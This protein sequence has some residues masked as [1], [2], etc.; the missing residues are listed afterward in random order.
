MNRFRSAPSILL[1]LFALAFLAPGLGAFG[2]L[3]ALTLT[4]RLRIEV[5]IGWENVG[6]SPRTYTNPATAP[7][8]IG[9]R[10]TVQAATD[11]AFANV[12]LEVP[13]SL[14]D[15]AFTTNVGGA[16]PTIV[17]PFD[18]TLNYGGTS[19]MFL[20]EPG[21]WATVRANYFAETSELH[22]R[23]IGEHYEDPQPGNP[24]NAFGPIPTG[25]AQFDVRKPR[26]DVSQVTV[27]GSPRG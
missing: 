19:G 26:V 27:S 25:A 7:R 18:G 12:V 22:W 21:A 8:V 24:N 5:P 14:P 13:V 4:G 23:V 15:V 17:P 11:D 20:I 3:H 6:T 1:A 16:L 9:Y 10:A 2:R